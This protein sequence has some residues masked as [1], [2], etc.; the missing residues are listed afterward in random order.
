MRGV[1]SEMTALEGE[2]FRTECGLAAAPCKTPELR[3]DEMARWRT[4]GNRNR[5]EMLLEAI[6]CLDLALACV[7][8]ACW[9]CVCVC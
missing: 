3:C 9:W 7:L 5:R 6:P 1:V 4:K 8:D 2:M